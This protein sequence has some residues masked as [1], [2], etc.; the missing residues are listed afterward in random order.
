[1]L[2][3]E[4]KTDENAITS[5][6][7]DAFAAAIASLN[8]QSESHTPSLVSAIFVTVNVEP[9]AAQLK[10]AINTMGK[11]NLIEVKFKLNKVFIEVY[12]KF[13]PNF[14]METYD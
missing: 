4:L 10:N 7:A 6:L 14:D 8:E 9:S 5:S 11:M 3:G 12:V 1:M 13:D 2:L